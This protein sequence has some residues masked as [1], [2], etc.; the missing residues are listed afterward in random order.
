MLVINL[1]IIGIVWE[2]TSTELS[3]H[4]I[5]TRVLLIL[6]R[7]PILIVVLWIFD[8]FQWIV[9]VGANFDTGKWGIPKSAAPKGYRGGLGFFIEF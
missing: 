7:F 9:R 5:K 4:K 1:G 3:I 6:Y 8:F 2:L